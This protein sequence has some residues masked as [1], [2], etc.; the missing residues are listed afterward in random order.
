MKHFLGVKDYRM[1]PRFRVKKREKNE[2]Y[3]LNKILFRGVKKKKGG[4]AYKKSGVYRQPK[5]PDFRQKCITKYHYSN[6]MA[7]HRKQL[8]EYLQKE[9][10]GIDGGV[11]ELIGTPKDIYEKNMVGK[12]IRLIIAPAKNGVPLN[13]IM[14]AVVEKLERHIGRKLY[15][16]G[17]AHYNTA[18]H[19]GHILINGKDALGRDVNIPPDVIKTLTREWTRDLITETIGARTIE[20]IAIEK[21]ELT[22]VPR[23]T[24]IDENIKK[25]VD[26][27]GGFFNTSGVKEKNRDVFKARLDYLLTLGLC[28]KSGSEYVFKYNYQKILQNNGRYNTYMKAQTELKF[29]D[30]ENMDAYTDSDKQ[31]MGVVTKLYKPED[32]TSNNHV[33]LVEAVDGRAYFIPLYQKPFMAGNKKNKTPSPVKE[34][35]FVRIRPI[36]GQRGRLTPFFYPVNPAELKNEIESKKLASKLAKSVLG[37]I[38][39][40]QTRY[41]RRF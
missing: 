5:A 24:Y 2:L 9:G 31:I 19:H 13:E 16:V 15:W 17:A 1:D 6:K 8:N 36:M 22:K 3:Y 26:P 14:K 4:G 37:A 18:H 38:D 39:E 11:P 23:W 29:T 27:A 34:G 20:E 30:K 10:K 7:A 33:A 35:E 40:P 41:G 28:E 32:D 25:H 21:N 12:N